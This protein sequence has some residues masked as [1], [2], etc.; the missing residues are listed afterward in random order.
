MTKFK[1]DQILWA[2][3]DCMN[4]NFKKGQEVKITDIIHIH[5]S[6]DYVLDDIARVPAIIVEQ[7]FSGISAIDVTLIV[8]LFGGPGIRK[9]TMA[10]SIF[11]ELKWSGVNA[12]LV[13]E[14]AKE[15]VWENSLKTLE[16]QLYITAKQ[17]HRLHRLMGQVEVIVTDSPIVLGLHY[18][19]DS[20][21][22]YKDLV[23]ALHNTYRSKN[24]LL[25]RCE[26]YNPIGRLQ[27]REGACEADESIR[28]ILISHNIEHT[29]IL[30]TRLA[31]PHV[32][33]DILRTLGRIKDE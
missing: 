16:D 17:N 6:T 2:K 21:Q 13:T 7:F 18:G 31:V 12:E 4:G 3:E 26:A 32:V 5:D 30:G 29:K 9:S 10:A 19:R 20:L 8:N 22:S 33:E 24:Y 14:Y 11:S 1:K 27:D 28:N 15:K 23:L 25:E